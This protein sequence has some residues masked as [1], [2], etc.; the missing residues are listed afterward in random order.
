MDAHHGQPAQALGSGW[1]AL[2]PP[3]HPSGFSR[4]L[5][6]LGLSSPEP[7]GRR[8]PGLEVAASAALVARPSR[9]IAA[10]GPRS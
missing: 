6:R 7:G 9:S 4:S 8:G 1:S 10:A 2:H 5:Q 3:G